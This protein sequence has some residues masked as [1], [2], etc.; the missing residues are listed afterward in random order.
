MTSPDAF[1]SFWDERVVAPADH[2]A[3]LDANGGATTLLR[4]KRRSAAASPPVAAASGG[5]P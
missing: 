2:G 5:T 4:V 3:F 1:A